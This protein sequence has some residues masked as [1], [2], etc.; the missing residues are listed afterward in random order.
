MNRRCGGHLP[1][2]IQPCLFGILTTARSSSLTSSNQPKKRIYLR[3]R[4][5]WGGEPYL[6]NCIKCLSSGENSS[7]YVKDLVAKLL[8]SH[9]ADKPLIS[10][11]CDRAD[12]R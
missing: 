8:R 9:P 10:G 6:G 11:C 5:V 3:H 2:T 12:Q 4:Y 1:R 7:E